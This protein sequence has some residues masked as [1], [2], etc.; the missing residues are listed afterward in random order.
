MLFIPHCFHQYFSWK[1]QAA[2]PFLATHSLL[3]VAISCSE[4]H[5]IITMNGLIGRLIRKMDWQLMSNIIVDV[6]CGPNHTPERALDA[7]TATD[8]RT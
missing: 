4:Y 7:R 2:Y 8:R 3:A 6:E 1:L 5:L